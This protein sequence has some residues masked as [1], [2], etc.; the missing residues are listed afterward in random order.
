MGFENPET[1][2]T[3]V[4][5]APVDGE[6]QG[7]INAADLDMDFDDAEVEKAAKVNPIPK[8]RQRLRIVNGT[9]KQS[10]E[11]AKVPGRPYF[12]WQFELVDALEDEDFDPMF[13]MIF[14]PWTDEDG[15]RHKGQM[16][17]RNLQGFESATGVKVAGGGTA[18]EVIAAGI[19]AEFE[20]II[21][22]ETFPK[23]SGIKQ[24]RVD[25]YC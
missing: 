5:D 21:K 6:V 18:A 13:D 1:D 14:I 2:T 7:G 12:N 22:H 10:G 24:A 3:A 15:R 17:M 16:Q 25:H 11:N 20:A 19:G 23:G 8:Q 9:L 4:D